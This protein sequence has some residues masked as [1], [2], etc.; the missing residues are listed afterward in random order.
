MKQCILCH[1]N[2][3]KLDT[4]GNCEDCHEI[5]YI[6]SGDADQYVSCDICNNICCCQCIFSCDNCDAFICNKCITDDDLCIK[7]IE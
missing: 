2:S 4:V 7:C 1:K 3:V 6:C 5:C